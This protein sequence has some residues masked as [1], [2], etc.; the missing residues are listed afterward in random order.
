M[1]AYIVDPETV[2]RIVWWIESYCLGEHF[3]VSDRLRNELAEAIGITP[4]GDGFFYEL[5]YAMMAL[6]V[7]A[8]RQR[9]EPDENGD[10]PGPIGFQLDA[11]RYQAKHTP[12]K[13]QVL[14]S[15]QCWLYQCTEGNVP[16]TSSLYQTMKKL[17]GELALM[18]VSESQ[19]YETA[20]WG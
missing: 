9:Y 18:I 7:E 4:C 16:E 12:S 11:Y 5:A 19:E 10:L 3:S 13:I 17:E 14:K 1:S 6:N 8:V 20:E 2:N 15:L